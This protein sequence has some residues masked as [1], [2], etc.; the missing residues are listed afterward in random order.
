MKFLNTILNI[1]FPVNCISCRKSGQ[2]LCIEC[3]SNSPLPER[4]NPNWIFSLFDY[5]H[6]PVKKAIWFLKYNGKKNIAGLFASIIHS[7]IIEELSDLSPMENFNK[8]ILI[9]IPLAPKRKRER[10]FNQAE[11][12]CKNLLKI[13]KESTPTKEVDWS[14]EKNILIRNL[15]PT[16]FSVYSSFYYLAGTLNVLAIILALFYK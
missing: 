1:I 2:I 7:R 15:D 8:I 9:P 11:L 12:I 4:E 10:G 6:P 5:R 3:L 14:I 13:H 16:Y